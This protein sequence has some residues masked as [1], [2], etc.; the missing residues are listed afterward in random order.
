MKHFQGFAGWPDVVEKRLSVWKHRG[1]VWPLDCPPP[2]GRGPKNLRLQPKTRVSET[3]ANW[4]LCR[5]PAQSLSFNAA[6]ISLFVITDGAR[7]TLA[8]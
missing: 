2:T 5:I 1:L 8:T 6:K 3:H 7:H 4:A